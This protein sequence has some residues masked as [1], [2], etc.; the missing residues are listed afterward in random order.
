MQWQVLLGFYHYPHCAAAY[1]FEM[2]HALL[3]GEGAVELGC[4]IRRKSYEQGTS[5]KGN[6]NLISLECGEVFSASR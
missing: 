4:A 6:M 1:D 2:K 3:K 5:A